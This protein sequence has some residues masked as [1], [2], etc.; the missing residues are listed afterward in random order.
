MCPRWK[1]DLITCI[2]GEEKGSR[3]ESVAIL[4]DEAENSGDVRKEGE[5]EACCRISVY[6]ALRKFESLIKKAAKRAQLK[7]S[8]PS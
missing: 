3:I 1:A 8:A 7:S 4:I 5:M 6:W 2:G